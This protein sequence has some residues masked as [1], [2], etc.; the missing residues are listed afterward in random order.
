[1][2]RLASI[3]GAAIFIDRRV[4][5]HQRIT[6][7][8]EVGS[9]DDALRS[10]AG[11]SSLGTSRM[12]RFGYLGPKQAAAQLRTLALVRGTEVARLPQAVRQNLERKQRLD[13][14][15]LAEPRGLVMS[16]VEQRGWRLAQAERIPHDLWPAGSLPEMTAVEQLTV[17]LIGFDLTFAVRAEQRRLE[18]VPLEPV[19]VQNRYQLPDHLSD[20]SSL[21]RNELPQGSARSWRIAGR[22]LIVDALVEEH[23][24]LAALLRGRSA[25]PRPRPTRRDTRQ[26]Y[27]LRVQEQP[28]GAVLRELAERL[29]WTI[30]IDEASIRAAGRSLDVH[31]TFAVE[32]SDQDELLEAVLRPA[33]LGYRREGERLRIVPRES[34]R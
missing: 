28:V 34:S 12:G 29:K 1:V 6:L 10:I 14:P 16:L 15:R 30:E 7:N 2:A 21:L 9:A 22:T 27:T 32:N 33:G 4:D 13:W 25:G 17:L 19:T 18:I 8:A 3:S 5:P 20:A 31:V 23:E 11:A 24:R 26:L